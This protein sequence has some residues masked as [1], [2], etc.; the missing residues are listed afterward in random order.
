MVSPICGE[1][2]DF[3]CYVNKYTNIVPTCDQS[4][5]PLMPKY[6]RGYTAAFNVVGK[7]CT[8]TYG[9]RVFGDWVYTEKS[10]HLCRLPSPSK[11]K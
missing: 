8:R 7:L 3:D 5:F 6:T 10:A 4:V 11:G 2:A 9:T 1:N